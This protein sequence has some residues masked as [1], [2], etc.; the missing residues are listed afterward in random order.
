[1]TE[2]GSDTLSRDAFLGGKVTLFQPKTGYRAGIDPVLLAASV[3]VRAGQSLLDLG[4]GAGAA[5][6][7]VGARVPGVA[8]TGVEQQAAYAALAR[9]NGQANGVDFQVIQADVAALPDALRQRQFD[10][11]IAN[12][13][14]FDPTRRSAATDAGREAALSAQTPLAIWIET[15]A[16]RLRA[17]GYLHLVLHISQMP[18]ALAA[19]SARL[20]SIEVLPVTARAGRPAHVILLRARM[21][22]RAAFRLHNPLVLHEGARHDR[23]GDSYTE[24]VTAVLRDGAALTWP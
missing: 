14:Y 24:Q 16:R 6:L 2:P 7:C 22:G 23:D 5:A 19:C 21:A 17:K 9:R 11:V 20:G 13:P 1:M 15:A 4:C 8:L 12:P 10:H 3:P 18:E